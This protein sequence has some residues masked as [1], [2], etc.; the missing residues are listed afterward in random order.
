MAPQAAMDAARLAAVMVRV[1]GPVSILLQILMCTMIINFVQSARLPTVFSAAM[2]EI[3]SYSS[4]V[5]RIRKEGKCGGTLFS[6]PSKYIDC[7]YVIWPA[8]STYF[9]GN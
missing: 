9:S 4:Y 8:H 5:T 3:H 2:C 7:C 1:H 6:I